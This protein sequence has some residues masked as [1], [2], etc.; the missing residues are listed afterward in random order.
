MKRILFLLVVLVVSSFAQEGAKYLIITHDNFYDAI[1]PLAQWK[2]QKGLP[3]RVVKLSSI[4]AT[5]ESLVRIRNYIVNAYNTWNPRPEYVLLVGSADFI[6]TDQNQFDDYYA[7]M[8][9]NYVMEISVGRFSCNNVSQCSVMVAKTLGYEKTPYLADTLWYKKGTGIVREDM[10]ASDSV[11]WQNLRYIFNLWQT[12]GYIHID[13]FSRI[14]GDSARHVEQAITNGR[15]FVVFRGQ[16]VTNWWSPFAINPDLM[17]N[18]YKLPVIISGTCATICLE[19]NNSYL[20]EAILRAGSIMNPKGAV[21]FF[22]TTNSTSGTGI[23]ILRGTVTTGFFR[24]IFIEG[25]YKLGDAS[26]RAKFLIDSIRPAG[27]T[28][29]RYREWNLLGDPELNLWT[30]VPKPLTIIYDS[31]I[32]VGQQNYI[33]T[34]RSGTTPLAN[35]LVCIMQDTF[36]YQYNNTNA[37]GQATFSINPQITGTM[38]ITVT[39]QNYQPQEKTVR[40]RTAGIEQEIG[41]GQLAMA[42]FTVYP[43]PARAYLNIKYQTSNIKNTNPTIKIYDVSGKVVG[44]WQL[45]I[46]HL[47]NGYWQ[48]DITHLPVGIYML[49]IINNQ[50]EMFSKIIKSK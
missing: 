26:K 44:Y 22:G 13:S 45:D 17:N 31:V 5:P 10:A 4:N 3:V 18:G 47:R 50:Q 42:N 27:Y 40:I 35:A 43:N 15:A 34:V 16:G 6:R 23:G 20:G 36:I 12:A 46:G 41:R 25:T 30:T 38:K 11:Y 24:S 33:V 28:S 14:Y 1:Q 32:P 9:G 37:A 39:K 7:N 29:T 19:P 21:A 2:H 49:G 8:V 48:L